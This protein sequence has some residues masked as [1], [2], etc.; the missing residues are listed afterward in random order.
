MGFFTELDECINKPCVHGSCKDVVDG[1][2]CTCEAGYTGKNCDEGKSRTTSL[3]T[4]YQKRIVFCI[5]PE[6]SMINY[7]FS[8]L[9]W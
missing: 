2:V 6:T 7:E 4:L 1:Y 9:F 3:S 5:V 8:L